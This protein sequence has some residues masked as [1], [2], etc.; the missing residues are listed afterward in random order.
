MTATKSLR[1]AHSTDTK[2]PTTDVDECPTKA[3]R[4]PQQAVLLL[5]RYTALQLS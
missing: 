3:R 2:D 5:L 4:R 1:E